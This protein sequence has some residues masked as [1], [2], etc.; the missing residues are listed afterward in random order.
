M[1]SSFL[2]QYFACPTEESIK[3]SVG[4]NS[5]NGPERKT[6]WVPDADQVGVCVFYLGDFTQRDGGVVTRSRPRGG[7]R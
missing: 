4:L 7:R 6:A 5:V 1:F 2:I 3:V